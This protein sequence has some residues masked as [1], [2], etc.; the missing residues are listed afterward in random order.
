MRFVTELVYGTVRM[1]RALDHLLAQ[2]SSRPLDVA[3]AARARRAAARRVPAARRRPAARGGGRDGERR[4]RRVRAASSTACCAR[5]RGS[6]PPWPLPEGDDVDVDR[7]PH[8][9]SRLDRAEL[10][11]DAS[12]RPTRSRRSSSTTNRRRSRCASNPMR[13]DARRR[14]GRAARRGRR[15][16]AR[17]RS[18]P[19]ALLVR[20]SG[21]LGAL[22]AVARRARRH[23]RTRP[24]RPS[25]PLL[26]PQPGDRVLDVASAPGRQGH[27]ERRSAMRAHGLV[28]AADLHPGRVR[29]VA[30]APP[31]GSACATR[32]R[33][34]S[35]T[36][37]RSR[38][39]TA[40][41]DRVLA[42]RAVHRA[43]RAAPP[44]RRALAASSPRDVDDLA[45]LQ[46]ALL[47]AR[48]RAV[49]PGRP[50]RLLRVHAHARET[51]GVDEF[52]A[53]A[54]SPDFVALDAARR[55]R[56]GRTGAG[57]ILLPSRRADRRH[58]RRA[59]SDRAPSRT[60]RRRA[61]GDASLAP[62]KIAP[63]DPRRRLRRTSRP[64]SRAS[65]PRP[66]CCT[67]TAWTATTCRTS[68]SGR[69]S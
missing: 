18:C 29:T 23:R 16:R 50:A 55:R 53:A 44:P 21:D 11:D 2:V 26:D 9:A 49:R 58:V 8:L 36:A 17:A 40:A 41:F 34:S 19:D 43:R 27:R 63:V 45:A 30:R 33:R 3:R 37:A 28:V 25:S 39:A 47:A 61:A 13:A 42:R 6:G 14:R 48:P 31:R 38:C 51:L 22:P 1:Q 5:W 35:P 20:H 67:S 24:A 60:A 54:T 10:V 56:G 64:T 68:R 59:S 52:A 12:A 32:S 66:T 62:M 65:P 15:G 46:R 4:R 7:R 57:A 69:R